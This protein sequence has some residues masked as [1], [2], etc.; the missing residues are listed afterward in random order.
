MATP[1]NGIFYKKISKRVASHSLT[2][3]HTHIYINHKIWFS[4]I[5]VSR[6]HQYAYSLRLENTSAIET[7]SLQT[8][9]VRRLALARRARNFVVFHFHRDFGLLGGIGNGLIIPVSK[10]KSLTKVV[11]PSF[12]SG[13]S[14]SLTKSYKI[15][16]GMTR[17]YQVFSSP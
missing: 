1:E 4:F 17:S 11:I 16:A 7:P 9:N 13:Q 3:T 15:I 6:V 12:N 14:S 2:H 10:H 8:S 5:L